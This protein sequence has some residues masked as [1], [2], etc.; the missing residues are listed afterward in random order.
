MQ[1]FEKRDY[2]TQLKP[3]I[4][5]IGNKVIATPDMSRDIVAFTGR[6]IEP[7]VAAERCFSTKTRQ[8]R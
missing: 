4:K 6:Y 3:L 8:M 5:S 7:F 2:K 1:L